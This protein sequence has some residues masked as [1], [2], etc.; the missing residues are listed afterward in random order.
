M[1]GLLLLMSYV[2]V[3]ASRVPFHMHES[4]FISGG[5]GEEGLGMGIS[6]QA[7]GLVLGNGTVAVYSMMLSWKAAGFSI[8]DLNGT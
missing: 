6:S 1:I 7:Q 5:R 8:S 3:G 4:T 2:V